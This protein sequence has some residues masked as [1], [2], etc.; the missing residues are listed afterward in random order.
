MKLADAKVPLDHNGCVGATVDPRACVGMS[1]MSVRARAEARACVN[2]CM[3]ES[4][5]L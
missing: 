5:C 3:C 4:V 1:A 2:V